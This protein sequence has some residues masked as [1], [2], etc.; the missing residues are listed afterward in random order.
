MNEF[1]GR[2]MGMNSTGLLSEAD[3]N[4]ILSKGYESISRSIDIVICGYEK[5]NMTAVGY[6]LT[7]TEFV[8]SVNERLLNKIHNNGN[9]RFCY[10][11]PNDTVL[12]MTREAI[13]VSENIAGTFHSKVGIVSQGFGHISTTLDPNWEGPLLISL[14][15]PTQKTLKFVLGND[16]GNGF[17]YKS[18]VTLMF[19]RLA[20][21]TSASHDNPS[22][23]MDI[24]QKLKIESKSFWLYNKYN[25]LR[26]VV[27]IIRDFESLQ[28]KIG[29]SNSENRL[30]KINQFHEKYKEF[31]RQIE[32]HISQAHEINDEIISIKKWINIITFVIVT[33]MIFGYAV[34]CFINF[35]KQTFSDK[36]IL[37][38]F[39]GP[40]LAPI[41]L[42]WL[43]FIVR[44]KGE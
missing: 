18:F 33:L 28:V 21:S 32:F 38:T 15:N 39:L 44:G 2:M 34:F 14:N 19:Y 31:S 27:D 12:I 29:Q 4:P 22:C 3:I 24:L 5:R 36:M 41:Y 13:W 35:D 30:D 7:P 9:E 8:F 10:I 42:L 25:K 1:Q 6:N 40:F 26:D 20:S 17:T 11:K 37:Y 16:N 23:R 43:K